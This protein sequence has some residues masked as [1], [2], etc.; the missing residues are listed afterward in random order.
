MFHSPSPPAF[1]YLSPAVPRFKLSMCGNKIPAFRSP[2]LG[3]GR[4]TKTSRSQWDEFKSSRNP[5]RLQ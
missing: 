5:V 3:L 1:S 4:P 2:Q